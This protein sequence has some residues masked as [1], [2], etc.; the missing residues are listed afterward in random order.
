VRPPTQTPYTVLSAP[1]QVAAAVKRD[2]LEGLLKPGD[3]LPPEDQLVSLFGVSR[4]TVRAGLQELC[5]AQI[6]TVQRGRNGGYRVGDFS[7]SILEKNVSELISLSLVVETLTPAQFFE[8]RYALE[9]LIA[10][11]AA[12]KRSDTSLAQLE[13]I[14]E[15]ANTEISSQEAFDLDLRFHRLLAEATENQLIVTFEGAM[16]AVLHRLLG[17]GSVIDPHDSLGGVT[18]VVDAVRAQDPATARRAM[19]THL[20]RVA[21]FYGLQTGPHAALEA[22]A[23]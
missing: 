23:P 2:I 15:R 20:R 4:P 7:L 12:V 9:L 21:T 16:I 8:V 6:L 18:D 1:Q 5:A 14:Q 22:I 10:E 3:R 19:Q 11:V 17:D 13:E